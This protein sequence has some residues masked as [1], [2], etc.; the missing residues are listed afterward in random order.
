MILF[1]SKMD[2]KCI[3]SVFNDQKKKI[4]LLEKYKPGY[5]LKID[6]NGQIQ[7]I[8]SS[9][10]KIP[11]EK[12]E[13]SKEVKYFENNYFSEDK[14]NTTLKSK[15]LS[16]LNILFSKKIFNIF[17]I[18]FEQSYNSKNLNVQKSESNTIHCIHSIYVSLINV[19]IDE[20]DIKLKET[21]INKFKDALRNKTNNDKKEK[22]Y[23]IY[24]IY[25][26]FVPLEFTL[27]GKYN[28][29][30]EVENIK[31][32]DKILNNLNNLTS[33][34]FD[35]E[36]LEI[37]NQ[38]KKVDEFNN[39][40]KNSKYTISLEGGDLTLKYSFNE[41]IKSL[42]I[43]NLEIIDFKTLV[44]IH[45]FCG[46]IK[47]EIEKILN[48]EKEIML[49]EGYN[50]LK[51]CLDQPDIKMKLMILGDCCTGKTSLINRLASG[52]HLQFYKC[53]VSLD[54]VPI[55]RKMEIDNK[56]Y[57]IKVTLI[58][59]AGAETYNSVGNSFIKQCDGFILLYDI[60]NK[61]TLKNINNWKKIIDDN[62]K[63]NNYIILIGN[64][65]D[66]ER[67]VSKYE[68]IQLSNE[69]NIDLGE[70]STCKDLNDKNLEKNIDF[71]INKIAHEII[72]R[73]DE[74]NTS[75][76]INDSDNF[77]SNNGCYC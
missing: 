76:F 27:G 34:S 5:S 16:D 11:Y 77:Y 69:L 61:F 56:E 12:I 55:Y 4:A 37:K 57:I 19:I 21:I 31:E 42:N 13:I 20:K 60:S 2:L 74:N 70:E 29:Y 25:G 28:I 75:I 68:A 35:T 62:S 1:N 22:L 24:D 40:M 54:F 33:F 23:E 64:K 18:E 71:L 43:D 46:D 9:I 53:T 63:K 45:E 8:Q 58:D 66:L 15:G 10:M 14:F 3:Y 6:S 73:D 47:Y 44:K 41:W 30:F 7:T 51:Y 59:T 50:Q 67:S 48:K 72:N 32:K 26:M 49:G 52:N 39:E 36:G 38:D 65:S 17:N